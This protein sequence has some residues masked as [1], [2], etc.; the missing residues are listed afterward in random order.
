MP[1]SALTS[2]CAPP[3]DPGSIEHEVDA[4]GLDEAGRILVNNM[5]FMTAVLELIFAALP[6]ATAPNPRRCR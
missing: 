5:K 4:N 1:T 3:K 2:I 6:P